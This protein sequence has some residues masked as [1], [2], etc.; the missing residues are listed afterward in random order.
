MQR[1]DSSWLLGVAPVWALAAGEV[2]FVVTPQ[3]E[4]ILSV[5]DG[6]VALSVSEPAALGGV[7]AFTTGAVLEGPV[8]LAAPEVTGTPQ[9]G[10]PLTA[11]QALWAHDGTGAPPLV[12]WRWQSDGVDIAGATA[13]TFTPSASQAG[14][15]LRVV[16]T[17]TD[18]FGTRSAASAPVT[19]AA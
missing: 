5:G 1:L 19:V 15:S 16:E 11:R 13:S 3:N 18:G 17:A 8:A 6:S 7:Y 10:T 14:T 4:V 12:D 2:T 9:V